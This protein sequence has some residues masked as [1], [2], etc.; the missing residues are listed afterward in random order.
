VHELK[1]RHHPQ[2]LNADIA[3]L[4]SS[5]LAAFTRLHRLTSSKQDTI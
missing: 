2:I 3:S 5:A 4:H 1:L